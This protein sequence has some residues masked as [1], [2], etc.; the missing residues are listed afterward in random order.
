[1]RRR[2]LAAPAPEARRPRQRTAPRFLGPAG[3]AGEHFCASPARVVTARSRIRRVRGPDTPTGIPP[4]FGSTEPRTGSGRPAAA[5]RRPQRTNSRRR[6]SWP[7]TTPASVAMEKRPSRRQEHSIP[8]VI[9]PSFYSPGSHRGA[10][11]LCA[12]AGDLAATIERAGVGGGQRRDPHGV[13][14]TPAGTRARRGRG[15]GPRRWS[16]GRACRRCWRCASPPP[17]A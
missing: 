4:L 15:G 13:I 8:T 11:P 7:R 12:A 2:R 6:R 9:R 17:P 1:M 5:P 10:V 3:R 16:G 14:P